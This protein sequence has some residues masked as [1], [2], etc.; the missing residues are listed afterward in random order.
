MRY[1]TKMVKHISRDYTDGVPARDICEKYGLCN[2]LALYSIVNKWGV[3]RQVRAG[4]TSHRLYMLVS[5]DDTELPLTAPS[6]TVKELADISGKK[7]ETLY[8]ALTRG[9][10]VFFYPNGKRF[11]P[12]R[13]KIVKIYLEE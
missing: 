9:N 5:D 4:R 8:A 11:K 2:E 12:V 13:A 6:E 7:L 10:I 3:K 1:T